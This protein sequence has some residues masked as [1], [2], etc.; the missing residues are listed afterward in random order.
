VSQKI[1]SFPLNRQRQRGAGKLPTRARA[2]DSYSEEHDLTPDAPESAYEI[3]AIVREQIASG[4][5]RDL[6]AAPIEKVREIF[7]RAASFGRYASRTELIDK[8]HY[9]KSSKAL[10]EDL[11][12]LGKLLP[13]MRKNINSALTGSLYGCIEESDGHHLSDRKDR[14]R[15]ARDIKNLRLALDVFSSHADGFLQTFKN[16]KRR[17]GNHD[18]FVSEFVLV[19]G[20]DLGFLARGRAMSKGHVRPFAYLLAAGWRDLDFPVDDHRGKSREP[21][22]EWFEDRIRKRFAIE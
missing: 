17:G 8:P 2:L 12:L 14:K 10:F 21:L 5:L 3:D 19:V 6:G 1:I 9:S 13:R 22:E 15:A 20:V 11:E 7:N 18:P 4:I 16:G